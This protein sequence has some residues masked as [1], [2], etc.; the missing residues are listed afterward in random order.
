MHHYRVGAFNKISGDKT[1][2]QWSVNEQTLLIK[3]LE[4][5]ACQLVLFSFCKELSNIHLHV[6][7]DNTISVQPIYRENLT[8]K[9]M[10]FLECSVMTLNRH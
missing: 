6:F 7:M 10:H 9:M 4:L 8:M 1:G 2:G 5:K 3:I